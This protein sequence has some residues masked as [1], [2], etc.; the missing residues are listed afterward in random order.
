MNF[1]PRFQKQFKQAYLPIS[2]VTSVNINNVESYVYIIS[3]KFRPHHD[4]PEELN[5][6]KIGYS[7][8]ATLK[9]GDKGLR[10]LS[11]HKTS[12]IEIKVQRIFLYEESDFD[13]PRAYLAEQRLH[14]V[15]QNAFR[16]KIKR[17]KFRGNSSNILLDRDSEW[18]NVPVK[19]MVSFLLFI[20]DQALYKIYPTCM[21]ASRFTATQSFTIPQDETLATVNTTPMNLPTQRKTKVNNKL[22]R[23]PLQKA[24][25]IE[26]QKRINYQSAPEAHE[27]P[28]Y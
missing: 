9:G 6:V 20:D 23:S 25:E 12:P 7:K 10:R 19:A 17:M 24:E 22:N 15:A 18:F 5:L 4:S 27:S 1:E 21:H 28:K 14:E 2:L 16:P 8:F 26:A 3:K 11:A 13:I